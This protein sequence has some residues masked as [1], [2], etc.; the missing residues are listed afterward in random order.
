ML[1]P[2]Q[3]RHVATGRDGILPGKALDPYTIGAQQPLGW[4][5]QG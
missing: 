1:S 3:L 2:D 4:Q 5:E